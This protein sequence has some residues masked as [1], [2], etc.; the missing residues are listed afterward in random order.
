MRVGINTGP[1]LLGSVGTAGTEFTAMGDAVNVASR[2]E[3]LAPEDGVL[4]SHSTYRHVRGV[5]DVQPPQEYSLRG[6]SE[7]VLAYVV[8]RAKPQA[9]R[10]LTRGVEGVETSTIG[11]A[12]ELDVP[13]RPSSPRASTRRELTAGDGPRGGGRRQVPVAVR[14]P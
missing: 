2:L 13:D 6:K 7:P 3:H 12:R 5:F 4:I 8:D 14:L 1:A 10:V 11:R 9:F